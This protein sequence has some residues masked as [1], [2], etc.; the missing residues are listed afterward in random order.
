MAMVVDY[1]IVGAGLTG[2]TIARLL[3]DHGREVLILDRRHH[4]GG[5][6]HDSLHPSQIRLHT[7]GPHYFRCSSQRVWEFVSRFSGF[8]RYEATVKSLVAG[9]YEN[10]PVNGALFHRFTGWRHSRSTA[11]P[12]NFEEA[13]LQKMPRSVYETYVKGYTRRHWGVDPRQLHPS[14]AERI[15]INVD[16]ETTLTPR[17]VYQ[18]LP[19]EGYHSLL[20]NMLEGIPCSLG[21]DYLKNRSAYKARRALVFTG[22]IDEFFGFEAGRLGYRSLERVHEFLPGADWYQPCGQVNHPNAGEH[23]A[24]RTMEWKHLMPGYLQ[25]RLRGTLITREY[26]FTPED[27]D[28][29]EYPVPT[30]ANAKLYRHYRR[31]ARAVPKLFVCGRLGAYRYLDMDKSIDLAMR[32]AE[33]FLSSDPNK[34]R[35]RGRSAGMLPAYSVRSV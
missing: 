5:N 6:V 7:Y 27:P 26:P 19:T 32:L 13:C 35:S 33:S 4:E 9:R 17:H 14:L 30:A 12:A 21:I 20:K 23:D 24:L 15:R 29:F 2:S 1:L 16:H 3:H 25:A 8:Y 22:P 18:G 10:W 31:R 28:R 11:T 34:S